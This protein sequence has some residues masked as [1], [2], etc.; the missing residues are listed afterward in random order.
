MEKH[1]ATITVRWKETTWLRSLCVDAPPAEKDIEFYYKTLCG[2]TDAVVTLHTQHI[3]TDFDESLLSLETKEDKEDNDSTMPLEFPVHSAAETTETKV[4][5]YI[6]YVNQVCEMERSRARMAM[7]RKGGNGTRHKNRNSP[8]AQRGKRRHVGNRKWVDELLAAL[9]AEPAT[10]TTALVPAESGAIP[11][12]WLLAPTAWAKRARDGSLLVLDA[13]VGFAWE[14]RL[15]T[16]LYPDFVVS[17]RLTT[18]SWAFQ[19][20]SSSSLLSSVVQ[21]LAAQHPSGWL[22]NAEAR[23]DGALAPFL[24]GAESPKDGGN[25]AA[26]KESRGP[27]DS[28]ADCG[29]TEKDGEKD[30]DSP[31]TAAATATTATTATIHVLLQQIEASML[32]SKAEVAEVEPLSIPTLT[33]LVDYMARSF[34]IPK[35]TYADNASVSAVVRRWSL[36]QR[37]VSR[38]TKPLLASWKEVWGLLLGPKTP[39]VGTAARVDLL[40]LTMDAWD[41][42]EGAVMTEEAKKELWDQWLGVFCETELGPQKGAKIPLTTME[43]AALAFLRRFL[44]LSLSTTK[45]FRESLTQ[46]LSRK[47]Y[48]STVVSGSLCVVGAKFL[49]TAT[50]SATVATTDI[51][52]V[53]SESVVH[54]GTL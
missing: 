13:A 4:A 49:S 19:H 14:Q 1:V 47:G 10:A 12:A 11:A 33:K 34:G 46:S 35:E 41:L 44:P 32:Y 36:S 50:V 17:R 3:P 22:R 43:D 5:E 37:G 6:H 26:P 30:K 24:G 25:A 29:E 27:K 53:A 48:S 21:W 45:R 8:E 7:E 28:E 38:K 20:S 54:L 15:G 51:P 16:D 52:L 18:A 31:E 9:K 2:F 39:V 42:V 23:V 40:V